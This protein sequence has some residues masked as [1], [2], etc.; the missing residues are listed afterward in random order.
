M[1]KY[2]QKKSL[3]QKIKR[4]REREKIKKKYREKTF[5]NAVAINQS[6]V[7]ESAIKTGFP[8]QGEVATAVVPS[9]FGPT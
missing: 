6:R 3:E 1:F 5:G 7:N 2:L 9:I 4:S 8:R